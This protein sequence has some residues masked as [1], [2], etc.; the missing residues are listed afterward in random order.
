MRKPNINKLRIKAKQILTSVNN[1]YNVINP[2]TKTEVL[3]LASVAATGT[4]TSTS[5]LER[6]R[7]DLHF[8]KRDGL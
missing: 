7:N 2:K 1:H 3:T 8:W 5:E 4:S 6:E